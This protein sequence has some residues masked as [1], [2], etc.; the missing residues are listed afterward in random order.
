VAVAAAVKGVGQGGT[1]IAA[2]GDPEGIA[3]E[4]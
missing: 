2:N 3:Q 4:T 1:R